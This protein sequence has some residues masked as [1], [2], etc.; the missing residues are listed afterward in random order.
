M[1]APF[2]PT[3]IPTPLFDKL[4]RNGPARKL[5]LKYRPTECYYPY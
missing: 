2:M 1:R 3:E 4:K 5:F